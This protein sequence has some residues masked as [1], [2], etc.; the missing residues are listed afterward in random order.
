VVR[1]DLTVPILAILLA[2]AALIGGWML[3]IS[4]SPRVL[5]PPERVSHIGVVTDDPQATVDVRLELPLDFGEIYE[6]V[7]PPLLLKITFKPG[8]ASAVKWAIILTE[9]VA[10]PW[11]TDEPAGSALPGGGGRAFDDVWVQ[12]D[13]KEAWFVRNAG[14]RQ[15]RFP[16]MLGSIIFGT[17]TSPKGSHDLTVEV[18]GPTAGPMLADVGQNYTMYLPSLGVPGEGSSLELRSSLKKL[19]QRPV[20]LLIGEAGMENVPGRLQEGLEKTVWH[21]PP[22]YTLTAEASGQKLEDRLVQV[23][24]PPAG[25]TT[26]R[27][28]AKDHLFVQAFAERPSR[29]A[30]SQRLQFLAGVLAGIGGGF[31][32]WSLELWYSVVAKR[33]G[34]DTRRQP[35]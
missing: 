33:P 9:D 25:P 16:N 22:S 3:F 31:L 7:P 6:D 27:W 29:I 11:S 24:Q 30:R 4:G 15:E 21:Y 32:I 1:R 20:S 13:V 28:S 17:T 19:R 2:L 5:Q 18:V 26:W 14:E 10:L 35:D 8:S 23:S 34:G 12:G